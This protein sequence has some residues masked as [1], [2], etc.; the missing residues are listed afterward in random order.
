[1]SRKVKAGMAWFFLLLVIVFGIA[2]MVLLALDDV[3]E[4]MF[5][6]TSEHVDSESGELGLS[7]LETMWNYWPLWLL[8]MLVIAGYSE[9][10]RKSSPGGG[11]R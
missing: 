1:M 10:V 2:T 9:A 4:I 11:I 8:G 5:A 3:V 7:T 6:S